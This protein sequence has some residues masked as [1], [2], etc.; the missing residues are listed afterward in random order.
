MYVILKQTQYVFR[1][2]RMHKV[3][4]GEGVDVSSRTANKWIEEGIAE[5]PPKYHA[6]LDESY[7]IG[8]VVRGDMTHMPHEIDNAI[9]FSGDW[10]PY[11]FTCHWQQSALPELRT[12]LLPVG[13]NLLKTWQLVIPLYDYDVLAQSIEDDDLKA[14]IH[15]TR[16]PLYDPRLM[17]VRRCDDMT[18]LFSRFDELRSAKDER[19]ATLQAIYECKPLVYA[20]PITWTGG[21]MIIDD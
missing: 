3:A 19:A 7:E 5:P 17:F 14:T 16:V 6:G 21:R 10:M 15:D 18:V 2:G 12:D 20:M 4:P 1:N 8:V 9:A 13:F 11:E